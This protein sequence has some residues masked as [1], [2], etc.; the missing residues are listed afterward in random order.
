MKT[1]IRFITDYIN[2]FRK[3]G[4]LGK[5]VLGG[6]AFMCL[7]LLPFSVL[8]PSNSDSV[9]PSPIA[10]ILPDTRNPNPTETTIPTVIQENTPLPTS[11]LT[12]I[13]T[14][15]PSNTPRPAS[16]K[17]IAGALPGLMPADVTVNLEQRG[18]TCGLVEQGQLYY[19]RICSVKAANYSLHIDI[20]GRE[21]FIVDYIG[22]TVLQFSSPDNEFAASFLGF[23]ATMPYDNAIPQE[24]RNWV[25]TTLPNLQGQGDVREKSFA[26]VSYRLYG[27]NT[28]LRLEMGTLPDSFILEVQPTETKIVLPTVTNSST[29]GGGTGFDNNGD[30]KVTCADFTTQSQALV[31]LRAGYTNLDR[32]SDG[33]PCE[34]LPK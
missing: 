4:C 10:S 5:I 28:A 33:I 26:G 13:P 6:I 27:L 11:T 29:G 23:M 18:L 3:A 24:A 12:N 14:I 19:S 32:D 25:E 31:A 9:T 16:T 30:G 2:S 21:P 20:Y 17:D 1:I 34:S 22:V 7:C 15:V 8:N